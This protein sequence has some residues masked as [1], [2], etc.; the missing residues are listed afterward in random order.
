MNQKPKKK[1]KVIIQP[2]RCLKC[3]E[4]AIETDMVD[5]GDVIKLLMEDYFKTGKKIKILITLLTK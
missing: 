2:P 5:V 1:I 3:R 4:R